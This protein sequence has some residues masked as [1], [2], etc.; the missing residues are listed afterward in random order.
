MTSQTSKTG[1]GWRRAATG[2]IASS[3]V[4]VGLMLSVGS[5][6]AH[7]DVLD[8]LAAQYYTGA[9]GG[10]ISNWIKESV[11]LRSMGFKPTKA[12]YAAIEEALNQ[13][14]NQ[15][16]L[17]RALQETV[18]DQRQAQAQSQQPSNPLT[19][20]INQYD[21]NNPSAIGGFGISGGPTANQPIGP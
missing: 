21:P 17:V 8:D 16:P 1:S 19:I 9:G 20:G 2:A 11:Q 3:A 7:A 13:R 10:Q 5:A 14:P 4:A 12:N 15:T 18:L 6:T